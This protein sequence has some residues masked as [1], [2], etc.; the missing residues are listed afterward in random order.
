M[1]VLYILPLL[2]CASPAFAA[3]PKPA[4][5]KNPVLIRADWS[6]PPHR[7]QPA[8]A[9]RPEEASRYVLQAR[10]RPLQYDLGDGW[11]GGVLPRSKRAHAGIG[12]RLRF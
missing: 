2:A 3:D 12:V 6:L 11:T 4:A 5:D 1:R 9:A 10:T 8:S 7:Q